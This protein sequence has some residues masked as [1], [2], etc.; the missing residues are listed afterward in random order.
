MSSSNNNS[1]DTDTRLTISTAETTTVKHLQTLINHIT[2][3]SMDLDSKADT[4]NRTLAS[5][6][7]VDLAVR[8]GLTSNSVKAATVKVK[9]VLVDQALVVEDSLAVNRWEVMATMESTTED[10]KGLVVAVR[11]VTLVREDTADSRTLEVQVEAT[12][13]DMKVITKVA[14]MVEDQDGGKDGT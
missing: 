6:N 1:K 10:I 8:E 13:A 2:N 5:T 7:R 14:D 11:A 4:I 3:S 9:A 12:V